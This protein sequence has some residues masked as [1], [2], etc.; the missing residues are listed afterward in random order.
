MSFVGIHIVDHLVLLF[1]FLVVLYLG[2]FL[3]GSKTKTL[4][5]FFVAGGRWGPLVSFVFVFASAVAGNEAVVVSGEAYHGGIS[6]VWYWWSFLFAT[7]FYFLFATYYRRAR[8]YNLAEFIEMRFGS[9]VAALYALVAGIICILFIGMFV[10]AISKILYGLT[11]IGLG[12][13]IAAISL[14]VVAYVCSGGMMSA[15]LTDLLQG[16]LCLTVLVFVMLPFLWIDAGG[17]EALR[18][19]PVD[20]WNFTSPGMTLSTV[21]ALNF[22]ALAGGIA[23]P[24]IY[25]WM[26]ISKNERAATQCAWGHLWK[27]VVTLIFALYGILFAIS[28]PGLA[29]SELAWGTVM[30]TVLPSGVGVVGLL[31]ASFFAAAMSSADTYA[32]TS[33]AMLVDYF[34]RKIVRRNLSRAH[35]LKVARLWGA[36]SILIAAGSTLYILSIQEYVKLALSLL[37]FLGIPIYFGVVWRKASEFG[38]WLSLVLGISSYL[39][40]YFLLTGEGR[41]FADSQEA[42]TTTVFVPTGLALVG[43]LLGSLL[44]PETDTIKVNRFHVILNTPIGN[45]SR[46]VDAGIVL[47][48][49]IDANL[50]AEGE[51]QLNI[52]VVQQLYAVDSAQKIFG[53]DSNIEVRRERLGWYLPG[54]CAVT[55]CCVLMVVGTWM[56]TRWLFVW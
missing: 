36:L 38:M 9:E 13:W 40:I 48:A 49:L 1:Y 30:K 34:Y 54:F 53:P 12:Y 7:P 5:D 26:A 43:M 29:D 11:D 22:S 45:E 23:A 33:S 42:F 4:G 18:A 17:F 37:S 44:K 19:L 14:I 31:M 8:V 21:L 3:G 6:G 24:W 47:P 15:L 25:N 46:L 28:A 35:Y 56:L 16:V 20:T 2:V 39:V 51:E 50:I 32:T 55:A 27:R 41:T 10:L 52:D